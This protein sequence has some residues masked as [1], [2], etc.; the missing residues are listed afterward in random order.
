VIRVALRGLR[1]NARR[2][3]GTFIA[4]VLGVSFMSGVRILGD[5]TR[6]SF[7]S[8]FATIGN[9]IDV[10]VRVTPRD[11]GRDGQEG[12]DNSGSAAFDLRTVPA[13]LATEVEAVDGV[14]AVQTVHETRRG[15][16]VVGRDGQPVSLGPG[17]SFL[18]SEYPTVP[19]MDPYTLARGGRAPQADDEVVLDRATAEAGDL[20]VGDAVTIRTPTSVATYRLVGTVSLGET[21]G[22]GAGRAL[23]TTAVA[24]SFMTDPAEASRLLVLADPGVPPDVLRDRVSAVVAADVTPTR[25]LETITG[26]EYVADLRGRIGEFLDI[27][28]N[29]LTGFAGLSLFVGAF[30]IYNT[31][32]ILVAQR[33]RELALLRAVGAAR[34]Q[35]VGAVLVEAAAVGAVAGIA[36]V[37]G[38]ALLSRGLSAGFTAFGF[39]LPSS[40]IVVTFAVAVTSFV[41]GLAM[42]LGCALFPA[43]RAARIPPIA[44]LRD[45]AVDRS[46]RSRGRLVVGSLF[47]VASAALLVRGLS[48]TEEGSTAA[49][50][51]GVATAVAFVAVAVL[52]PLI[53]APIARLVGAPLLLAGTTGRLARANATRNPRRTAS[54]AAALMIGVSI[55]TFVLVMSATLESVVAETTERSLTADVIVS[56]DAFGR[57]AIAG[58]AAAE[59]AAVSGVVKVG[60]VTSLRAKYFDDLQS[61]AAVSPDAL[62]QAV[63]TVIDGSLDDLGLDGVAVEQDEAEEFG[64]RVGDRIPVAF[65]DGAIATPRIVAVLDNLDVIGS[66]LLTSSSFAEQ[67]QPEIGPSQILVE[68]STN[69]STARIIRDIK[70]IPILIGTQVQDLSSY[71]DAQTSALDSILGIF[72]VM[73][74]LTVL[75]ALFGIANTLSLSIHE[76]TRE[77]GM[78]RAVGTTRRQVGRM[79][80]MESV[81]LALLGTFEGAVIGLLFGWAIADTLV[82]DPT[83]PPG[84][85]VVLPLGQV[86]GVVLIAIV[87]GVVAAATSARRAR[88]LDVLAAISSE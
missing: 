16:V 75:I 88:R 69:S 63:L 48:V 85:A 45:I 34:R 39:D 55:V 58:D 15:V 33:Q 60:T 74:A 76:R 10:V 27:L 12:G 24:T 77:I 73:L 28:Q 41:I 46:D 2:L 49:V 80:R 40:T 4:I 64:L 8:L 20:R 78:L 66:N 21:S 44:A 79:V 9:G 62:S 57:G 65:V 47:V 30:V 29:G 54:T 86:A 84:L 25:K 23:F 68:T 5:T 1:G 31:F 70:A 67:Y 52:G 59:I 18:A 35:V 32:S 43:L 71:A 42:A 26:E 36:G 87:A 6:A 13:A 37:A 72:G 14:A 81:I 11:D 61:L 38:G 7:D 51:V 53:S 17:I 19:A 22:G 50:T 82:S 83:A 3:V 56:G